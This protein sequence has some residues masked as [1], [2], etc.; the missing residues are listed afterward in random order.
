MIPDGA[1][2]EANPSRNYRLRLATPEE[3]AGIDLAAGLTAYVVAAR[4]IDDEGF[5]SFL[6]TWRASRHGPLTSELDDEIAAQ[7]AWNNLRVPPP[8]PRTAEHR[9]PGRPRFDFNRY[10]SLSR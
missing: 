10:A 6:F 9:R 5:Q 7:N 4:R 8:T 1:F 3:I 2:F